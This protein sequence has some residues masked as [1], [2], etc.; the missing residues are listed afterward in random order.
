M[1]LLFL[2]LISFSAF[3]QDCTESTPRPFPNPCPN[4][5]INGT[6]D[7]RGDNGPV[8]IN[9]T[10]VV[11]IRGNILLDGSNG[12]S[13]GAGTPG[14]ADGPAGAAGGEG[15]GGEI[16][17]ISTPQNGQNGVLANG[18][19]PPAD[20]TCA[21]GGSGGGLFTAGQNGGICA[22]SGAGAAIAGSSAD[23]VEF[24]FTLA[25]FR[26]G[27]GG[28][29]GGILGAN[30]GTGGGGGGALKIIAGGNVT[31][32][33]GVTISARGGNGGNA[34]T[35]D[36]AGGGGSGGALWI[37]S[38]GIIQ[39]F[40]TIDL[41]GGNGGTNPTTTGD[42]GNGGDGVYQFED[43]NGTRNGSGLILPSSTTSSR[44]SLKSNISCGT[45][46]S[47]DERNTLL[48]QASFAFLFIIAFVELLKLLKN[49]K[50]RETTRHH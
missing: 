3:A 39:N 4:L 10:G 23:G 16:D 45:I 9:V 33:S 18:K 38:S 34:T 29:A 41:R 26:G 47:K 46:T 31:V 8:V 12:S 44:S 1:G 20:L 43:L 2:L 11:E 37:Q 19:A 40:G 25:L 42:G 13:G 15:E 14:G 27:Y 48:A 24:D 21:N 22:T 36:G 17:G 30:A 49:T 5:Y 6:L 7:L 32:F 28:G 35:V 50:Y